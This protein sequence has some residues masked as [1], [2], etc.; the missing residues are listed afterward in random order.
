MGGKSAVKQAA[1]VREAEQL[2]AECILSQAQLDC[3]LALISGAAQ[4]V[5]TRARVQEHKE[6]VILAT[7]RRF[8]AKCS[9][10]SANDGVGER[11]PKRARLALPF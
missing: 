6:S 8:V 1:A 5:Q 2:F 11:N 4:G 3:E 10:A 9:S 7:S